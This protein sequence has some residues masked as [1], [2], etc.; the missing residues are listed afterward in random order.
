[1]AKKVEDIIK[2]A[3]KYVASS[4]GKEAIKIALQHAD[5]IISQLNEA[6]QLDP[7][8]LQEPITL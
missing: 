2:K 5:K 3:N 4:K 1:M 7:K 8:S 6:R